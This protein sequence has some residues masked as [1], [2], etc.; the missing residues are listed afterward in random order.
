[1]S[2]AVEVEITADGEAAP[3][4]PP[5]ETDSALN[6]AA[7]AAAAALGTA[8][9]ASVAADVAIDAGGDTAIPIAD[10]AAETIGAAAAEAAAA[11]VADAAAVE[12]SKA[13]SA[14]A[15]DVVAAG[16]G[17][18]ALVY[19]LVA[20][21]V[22]VALGVAYYALAGAKG[23]GGSVAGGKVRSKRAV[24]LLGPCGGG[25][26]LA[27]Q[28][29]LAAAAAAE[30]APPP[31]TV[32]SMIAA[33]AD[34]ALAADAL[35][36]GGAGGG[37]GIGVTVVDYPGHARLRAGLPEQ[38]ARSAGVVLVVDAAKL[39]AQ[40]RPAA[41]ILYA[42]LT[43]LAAGAGAKGLPD[44]GVLVLCNKTDMVGAK[45][46]ARAKLMLQTELEALRKTTLSLAGTAGEAD[47]DGAA[48]APLGE[49]G[50]PFA[51]DKDAPCAVSFVAASATKGELAPL[52]EFVVKCFGG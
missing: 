4:Y 21:G 7:A 42:V 35:G 47:G 39:A 11:T 19:A 9:A 32:T 22:L 2:D 23:A 46:P 31:E 45:T 17:S 20:V 29:L 3:S 24:L 10:A 36:G 37:D 5:A 51:F 14:S 28:T 41:E 43:H 1:M 27:Y 30:A 26:T 18:G 38:L 13:A 15:A 6:D 33:E 12:A 44:N 25:K 40:L 8:A 49:A 34:F 50:R 48:G 52:C 16:G